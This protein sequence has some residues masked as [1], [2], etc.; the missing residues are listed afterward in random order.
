LQGNA[1][2]CAHYLRRAHDD[3]Y[4]ILVGISKDPAFTEIKND[5]LVQE[6]LQAISVPPPAG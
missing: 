2:R 3:G 1:E 5:P 4:K 6:F